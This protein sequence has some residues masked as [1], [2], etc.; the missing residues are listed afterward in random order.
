MTDLSRLKKIDKASAGIIE[1]RIVHYQ[2]ESE[3]GIVVCRAAIIVNAWR[4]AAYE[5]GEVN[6]TVFTDW[7]NDSNLPTMNGGA[8]LDW[9][10]SVPHHQPS[11]PGTRLPGTWHWPEKS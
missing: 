7:T 2:Y 8:A 11:D 1:G 10:T 5:H 6:L 3:P 4:T 9:K